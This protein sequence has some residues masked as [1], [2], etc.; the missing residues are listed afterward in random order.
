MPDQ[1]KEKRKFNRIL[2]G[3]A[4]KLSLNKLVWPCRVIDLSLQGCLLELP[5][6]WKG[7]KLE[8]YKLSL[9]L[10]DVCQIE[11]NLSL[12]YLKTNRAGFLCK[13][14]DIESIS[15][16]RRLLELN[17]GDSLL[18]DRDLTALAQV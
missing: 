2:F 7:D 6:N 12:V 14:I 9:D 8:E 4:A 15:R 16:L 3:S 5:V 1:Q 11:M 10:A 17:L 13:E 18:L